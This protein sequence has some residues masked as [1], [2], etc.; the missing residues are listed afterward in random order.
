MSS[1]GEPFKAMQGKGCRERVG[2]N[3]HMRGRKV[4]SYKVTFMQRAV[5]NWGLHG[6]LGDAHS[7][8]VRKP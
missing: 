7:R 2:M 6:Y 3:F 4:P 8:P 1:S 5:G